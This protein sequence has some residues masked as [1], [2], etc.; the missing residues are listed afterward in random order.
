[1]APSKV[2]LTE[3]ELQAFNLSDPATLELIQRAQE[4]DALDKQLTVKEALIKY[5]KAV[6]WA[7]CLSISLVMEGYDLVIVSSSKLLPAAI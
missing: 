4:S 2:V 6:F 5:K 3:K 1:M 7:M